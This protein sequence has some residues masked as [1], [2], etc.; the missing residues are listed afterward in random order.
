MGK[1]ADIKVE[2]SVLY[3]YI[4]PIDP[5][6]ADIEEYSAELLHCVRQLDHKVTVIIETS[7]AKVLKAEHRIAMGNILKNNKQLILN[8][9]NALV[10]VVAHPLIQFVINGIFLVSKPP[11]KY[12][13]TTDIK[14]AIKWIDEK[15]GVLDTDHQ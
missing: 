12:H 8:K 14:R 7:Q 10:Y 11:V 2:G 6:D 5:T 4:N 3:N 1:L 15:Y 9:V 13:V